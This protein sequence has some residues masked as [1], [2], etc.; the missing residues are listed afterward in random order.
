MNLLDKIIYHV[1]QPRFRLLHSVYF[2]F[3]LLPIK[4]AIKMPIHLYGPVKFHW[5]CGCIEI[6][7]DKVFSGM[8]KLGRNNEYFNG[9]DGSSFISIDKNSKIIFTG[10]CAIGNNYKIRVANNAK[11]IFGAYTF[12]GSSVRF[13]CT[14]K[15]AIGSYTR[16][17]YESQ[18]VDSN[19]HF[20]V[21]TGNM[22]VSRRDGIITIGERNWIGNRTSIT[23]GCKTKDDTI[24]CAGSLLNK[25]YTKAEEE[26]MMLGGSPA[27]ILTSG[28]KRLFST[29]I[30]KDIIEYFKDNAQSNV[31]T[32]ESELKDDFS[33][34]N[35]WFEHIM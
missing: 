32:I 4:Q 5:L 35:Y 28:F 11:L 16:C 13:I 19:F 20:V 14:K 21:N 24:V 33:D 9:V 3:R 7:S 2:N 10:P 17:A 34:I 25:D 8:I 23:K 26:N 18:F 31:Y 12:F 30:E 1:S 27:K 22:N 6:K 29:S 15:I